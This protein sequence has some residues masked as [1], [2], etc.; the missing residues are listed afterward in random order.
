MSPEYVVHDRYKELENFPSFTLMDYPLFFHSKSKT[1]T[2]TDL[3]TSI[4]ANYSLLLALPYM[5]L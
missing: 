1:E 5:L 2:I 3:H 4:I